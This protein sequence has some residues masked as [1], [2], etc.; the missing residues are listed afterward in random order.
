MLDECAIIRDP[1][2]HRDDTF[3]RT[4]GVWS[5]PLSDFSEVYSG[6]CSVRAD[7]NATTRGDYNEGGQQAVRRAYTGRIPLD[8]V[9]VDETCILE[10]TAS[11]DPRLEG[12]RFKLTE[13]FG[14]TFAVSRKFAL[15]SVAPVLREDPDA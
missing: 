15:T 10:V 3:N 7:A 8:A 6:P 2:G 13:V 5:R 1:S 4:T 12:M 11:R 9:D 14:S